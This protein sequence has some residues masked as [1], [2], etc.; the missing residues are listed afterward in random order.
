MGIKQSVEAIIQA[1]AFADLNFMDALIPAKQGSKWDD[2][3]GF[4]D[5]DGNPIKVAVEVEEPKQQTE[6]KEPAVIDTV[7]SEAVSLDI[8]R[9]TPPFWGTKIL[10][11]EI[12]LEDL[13]WH[14]D[15]QALIAGQWQ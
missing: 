13:F 5:D 15:L 8:D 11:D 4:L 12:V 10:K 14:M 9:P 3:H 6:S 7:R 1:D 2:T